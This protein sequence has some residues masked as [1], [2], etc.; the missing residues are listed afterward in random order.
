M[1]CVLSGEN[2]RRKGRLH[3]AQRGIGPEKTLHIERKRRKEKEVFCGRKECMS[4]VSTLM[5][6]Q[7]KKG[8]LDNKAGGYG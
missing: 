5:G 7:S 2:T 4:I 6:K 3:D 1:L 8:G